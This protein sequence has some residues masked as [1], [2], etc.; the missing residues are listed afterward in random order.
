[1]IAAVV[2][3]PDRGV[4]ALF[5]RNDI[6]LLAVSSELPQSIGL[7]THYVAA[8]WRPENTPPVF[9]N[10]SELVR[11]YSYGSTSDHRSRSTRLSHSRPSFRFQLITPTRH[12]PGGIYNIF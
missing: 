3:F 12:A 10:P 2:H 4:S 9:K 7:T 11:S 6:A 1:M 8:G 5:T